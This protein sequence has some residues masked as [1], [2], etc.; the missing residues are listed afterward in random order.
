MWLFAHSN[1]GVLEILH[2]CVVPPPYLLFYL[3]EHQ[4]AAGEHIHQSAFQ[5]RFSLVMCHDE[6]QTSSHSAV[7]CQDA[8]FEV[9]FVMQETL[10]AALCQMHTNTICALLSPRCSSVH[11]APQWRGSVMP[12]SFPLNCT[13]NVLKSQLDVSIPSSDSYVSSSLGNDKALIYSFF[14]PGFL[15]V[16]LFETIISDLIISG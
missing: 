14:E 6:M 5:S 16:G 13:L 1:H 10:R 3:L 9:L 8:F 15:I 11:A 2:Q 12:S 4:F 7:V